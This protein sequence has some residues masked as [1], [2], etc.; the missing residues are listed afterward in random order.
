MP[1]IDPAILKRRGGF[2]GTSKRP[3]L[4]ALGPET[5]IGAV[6]IDIT[7]ANW[8]A[9]NIISGGRFHL[10]LIVTPP[11]ELINYQD[12]LGTLRYTREFEHEGIFLSGDD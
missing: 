1:L 11:P 9:V 6:P 5:A 4:C 10:I 3:S 7:D 12:R 8:Q 2:S